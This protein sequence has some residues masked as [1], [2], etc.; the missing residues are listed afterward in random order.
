MPTEV[1][2]EQPQAAPATVELALAMEAPT[3]AATHPTVEEPPQA[4]AAAPEAAMEAAEAPTAS[5][6][7]D[8]P[9]KLRCAPARNGRPA[10]A[11][12]AGPGGGL[13]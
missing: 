2:V 11:E 8:K 3:E 9:G 13:G 1:L 7:P 5:P 10:L 4:K 6:W 12:S